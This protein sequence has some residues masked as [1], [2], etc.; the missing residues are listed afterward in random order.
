M[1]KTPLS[2]AQQRIWFLT[3]FEPENPFY[4]FSLVLEI[5]GC[6]NTEALERA[7]NQLA[8]RHESLRTGFRRYDDEIMQIVY[9]AKPVELHYWECSNNTEDKNCNGL[10]KQGTSKG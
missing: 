4:H 9:P 2:F 6:L 5:K 7:I 1:K 3:Q 8:S 10:I